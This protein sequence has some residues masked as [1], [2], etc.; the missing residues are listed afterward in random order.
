VAELEEYRADEEFA[1]DDETG[2][3]E[4]LIV[5]DDLEDLDA[6]EDLEEDVTDVI[7]EGDVEEEEE[8]EAE[9]DVEEL[10]ERDDVVVE[11]EEEESLDVLLARDK[12]SDDE[13]L[14]R[15]EE[16]RD[17]LAVPAQPIGAQEFTCRSCFLVKNRAQ[18]ADEDE[19]I[20]FDC[21]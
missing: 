14:G 10:E 19:L 16:P 7:E 1:E 18:L 3:E 11:D 13:D 9:E 6:L 4:D 5:E 12:A 17:G 15:L 20:C 2:D 21:A 8:E